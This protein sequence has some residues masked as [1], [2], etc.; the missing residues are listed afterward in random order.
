[1]TAQ[2]FYGRVVLEAGGPSLDDATRGTAA[3]FHALRDRPMPDDADQG[4][5]TKGTAI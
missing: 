5:A 2:S 4:G 3:V 1:M